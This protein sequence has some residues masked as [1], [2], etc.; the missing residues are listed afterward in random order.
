MNWADYCILGVLALSVLI[1]LWRGLISEVMALACWAAAFWL[2]WMFGDKVAAQFT[3]IEVPSVRLLLGYGLCFLTVL[4]AGALISFVLRKLI[5]GSGLSGTDRMFG[6]LFGLA[7][8][9]LVVMLAVLMLGFTPLPR[10]PWW[11]Q[12]SLLPSFQR[13]AEW[14]SAQLPESVNK[15]L[16]FRGLPSLPLL[17]AAPAAPTSTPPAEAAAA[18][19]SST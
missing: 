11:R 6:M 13:G 2:A 7:R 12:S 8:G 16:D 17:P 19:K 3:S 5:A 1:G 14:L 9:L 10:D 4:I 15:Y 18:K